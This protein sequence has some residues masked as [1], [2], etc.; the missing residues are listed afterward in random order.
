MIMSCHGVHEERFSHSISGK[1]DAIQ[2]KSL[3]KARLHLTMA[4]AHL[5]QLLPSALVVRLS[6][7]YRPPDPVESFGCQVLLRTTCV[8]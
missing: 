6:S 3:Q 1:H 8:L 2:Q 4:D 5:K 7:A